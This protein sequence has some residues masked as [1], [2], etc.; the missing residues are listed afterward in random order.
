MSIYKIKYLKYKTKYLNLKNNQ[1]LQVGSGFPTVKALKNI[2]LFGK[3]SVESFNLSP[4]QGFIAVN[5]GFLD[6]HYT[7]FSTSNNP[8]SKFVKKTFIKITEDE[9][10]PTNE[11]FSGISSRDYGI[12]LGSIFVLE[13]NKIIIDGKKKQLETKISR[14][15]TT[16]KKNKVRLD[17]KLKENYNKICD[18]KQEIFELKK[19]M[20]NL[21]EQLEILNYKPKNEKINKYFYPEMI[22]AT[23]MTD[24]PD[25]VYLYWVVLA[26]LWWTSNNK[27]GIKEYYLGINEAFSL[28][29]KI[30]P[31]LYLML[32]EIPENWEN[33]EFTSAELNK[34]DGTF[35]LALVKSYINNKSEIIFYKF[36][37]CTVNKTSFSDCGETALRN[38]INLLLY[39]EGSFNFS[40]LNKYNAI[41]KLKEYYRVFSNF[42]LQ[43]STNK[44]DI[45]GKKLNA[46]DAWCYVISELPGAEYVH[47]NIELSGGF[48]NFLIAISKLFRKVKYITDFKELKI[49]IDGEESVNTIINIQK[50][51]GRYEIEITPGHY[52]F[53]VLSQVPRKILY[54]GIEEENAILESMDKNN[55]EYHYGD[56][57]IYYKL[58]DPYLLPFFLNNVKFTKEEYNAI[59]AWALKYLNTSIKYEIRPYIEDT[60]NIDLS[61]YGVKYENPYS[62][63]CENIIEIDCR[64]INVF[65]FCKFKKI[66]TIKNVN[67]NIAGCCDC[68][69]E[70]CP[71]NIPN[72]VEN[73]SFVGKLKSP[74]VI[75]LPNLFSLG[76]LGD[77]NRPVEFLPDS[78]TH[79]ILGNSFKQKVDNLPSNLTHLT[80]GHGFNRQVDNLPSNLTHLTFGNE[81]KQPVESLPNSIT[82]LTFGDAFNQ[83]VDKLPNSITHLTFGYMFNQPVKSLP[84]SI[85]HLTFN[86]SSIFNL[87][88]ESLPNSITHL[89]FGNEF[90]QP[91]ETLPNS[92]THLTFGY[93]F[94]QPVESL[95]N[96]ITHLTF[97][98]AFN[99]PVESLPNSITHLTFGMDFNHPVDKLPS[100]VTHLTFGSVFNQ[101]VESL[102]NSITHLTFGYAFN[103]PV[104]S[105]PNSITHL[106]FGA[107][108]N[109][110]ID[111]LPDSI[112]YLDFGGKQDVVRP[113]FNQII[114]KLPE[115]LETLILNRE[116]R[117]KINLC[118]LNHLTELVIPKE[119]KK[120]V[121]ESLLPITK[122]F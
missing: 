17:S 41:E 23:K 67:L 66:K 92:I 104:E 75:G 64:M 32:V 1:S 2:D 96:S 120:Y 117:S 9:L 57:Y 25:N 35:E 115:T 112:V 119:I 49:E 58:T 82:H 70:D 34:P 109:Q 10:R 83:P 95:P 3:Y 50:K 19:E 28:Y 5:T 118:N 110:P 8:I 60:D 86:F 116:Y 52:Q 68:V 30:V 69:I 18:N 85:T 59:L 80:F 121:P 38:F 39:N 113:I 15:V 108:F 46:R 22:E 20:A 100:S 106:T 98:Y 33:E 71:K 31:E 87:S 47:K 13:Q 93:A 42:S 78:I 103:Q 97:G 62:Y 81:F 114:N 72:S 79:L 43:S 54:N 55:Y 26:C 65:N 88:V 107:H 89:T 91:V 74:F 73:I 56:F 94:N 53:K 48:G 7:I 12:F 27:L 45:F 40:I 16:I 111:S 14:L 90:K 63:N 61:F 102:P 24:S 21:K 11:L 36:E 99:Q 122:F 4:L 44:Q 105:L 29:K 76:L 77:F 101:P 51:G 6:N 84:N 37:P